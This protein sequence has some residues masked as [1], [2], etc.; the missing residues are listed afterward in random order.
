MLSIG[1]A[2][3]MN[4]SPVDPS[5]KPEVSLAS[6]ASNQVVSGQINLNDVMM[7]PAQLQAI[8]LE[9][10]KQMEQLQNYLGIYTFN[11]DARLNG[12]RALKEKVDQADQ[13][14]GNPGRPQPCGG[15]G[16]PNP[17]PEQIA[18][19][20]RREA[21]EKARWEALAEKRERYYALKAKLSGQTKALT[22]EILAPFESNSIIDK[23]NAIKVMRILKAAGF[24]TENR[25]RKELNGPYSYTMK[26]R[27]QEEPLHYEIR[28]DITQEYGF[29]ID[30]YGYM[31]KN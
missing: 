15:V 16:V 3:A 21:E 9:Q 28:K 4:Y 5:Q 31:Y 1:K 8:V 29:R 12:I 18:E 17:T 27:L 30:S 7:T 19:M 2:S 20:A 14:A 23:M 26:L 6:I 11:D 10:A 25:E 24:A 22:S 13:K